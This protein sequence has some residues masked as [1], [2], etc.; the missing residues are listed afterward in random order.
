MVVNL[1]WIFLQSFLL[2][3]KLKDG[4][5]RDL[6]EGGKSMENVFDEEL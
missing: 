4:K 6:R 5:E 3:V 2:V 1:R